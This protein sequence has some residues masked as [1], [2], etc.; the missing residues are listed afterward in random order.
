MK[1]TEYILCSAIRRRTPRLCQPYRPGENDICDIEIG[2]RNHDIIQRFGKEV[3]D[4]HSQGFYTSK[5]RFV[6]RYE[7]SRVALEA[8]QID[9][10][11]AITGLTYD[12]ET[13]YQQLFS[14]DLY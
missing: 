12:G 11:K 8:G 3:L 4:L 1:E 10:S 14:E 5:G 13:V 6:D 7:A 2:F 9:E